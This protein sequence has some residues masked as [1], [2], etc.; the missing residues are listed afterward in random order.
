MHHVEGIQCGMP[1]VYHADGGGIVEASEPCGLSFRDNL[2][3]TILD[4]VKRYDELL[5]NMRRHSP[6]GD[7]MVLENFQLMQQLVAEGRG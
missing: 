1:I 4:A 7:K 5:E 6:S 2:K 3:E